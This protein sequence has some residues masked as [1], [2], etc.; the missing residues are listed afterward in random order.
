MQG[1]PDADV[2]LTAFYL[3]AMQEASRWCSVNVQVSNIWLSLKCPCASDFNVT[4]FIIENN[5]ITT[6][7]NYKQLQKQKKKNNNTQLINATLARIQGRIIFVSFCLGLQSMPE[8]RRGAVAYI[9][10][11]LPRVTSTYAVAMA[12]Y[13]L[14]N[15]NKFNR[16]LLYRFI[17]SGVVLLRHS[18]IICIQPVC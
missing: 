14:A 13:A 2:S 1:Y 10:R 7:H 8:T 18:L 5:Y 4:P 11:R 16:E 17:S 3:I 12:S 6:L 15:E 9:E